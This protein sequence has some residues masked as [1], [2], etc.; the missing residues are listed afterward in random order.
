MRII[1]HRY[2]LG[3]SLFF[4]NRTHQ[5]F[6]YPCDATRTWTG[7]HYSNF[8]SC[9]ARTWQN[10]NR[11]ITSVTRRSIG[12]LERS[13]TNQ[14]NAYF[15][16]THW[17]A[18]CSF[19]FICLKFNRILSSFNLSN[20]VDPADFLNLFADTYPAAYQTLYEA[21]P[22]TCSL[23]STTFDAV[24]APCAVILDVS[25]P[26]YDSSTNS[27]WLFLYFQLLAYSQL[28]ATRAV[29]GRS[30]PIIA[31]AV[32]GAGPFIRYCGP[33][34]MG[35]AGDIGTKTDAEVARTGLS[36]DEIGSKVNI[37]QLFFRR[38]KLFCIQRC[39]II[40][41]G[42]SFI[43]LAFLWCM[44]T[45]FSLRRYDLYELLE[46]ILNE[47]YECLGQALPQNHGKNL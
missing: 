10:Q 9:S 1:I 45:N 34:F 7:N 2:S 41:K 31:L 14:V 5:A 46:H 22:I 30:V 8:N 42:N 44:T 17:Y 15:K 35:G 43:F 12:K 33:E 28:Q 37:S 25:L 19:L 24:R 4:I 26:I 27:S 29:T 18:P 47:F 20:V 3:Y 32:G 11:S 23:T 40:Q 6:L 21:K 38:A 39:I 16:D 13:S 36:A